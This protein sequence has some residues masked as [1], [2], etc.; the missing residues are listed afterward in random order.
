MKTTLLIASLCWLLLMPLAYGA[1]NQH[2]E[3]EKA[4]RQ[5]CSS[6]TRMWMTNIDRGL[7]KEASRDILDE[8]EES[9]LDGLRQLIAVAEHYASRPQGYSSKRFY[10]VTAESVI[11]AAL[12]YETTRFDSAKAYIT[13]PGDTHRLIKEAAQEYIGKSLELAKQIGLAEGIENEEESV[14]NL[15]MRYT[16]YTTSLVLRMKLANEMFVKYKMTAIAESVLEAFRNELH[17]YSDEQQQAIVSQPFTRKL[18]EVLR[19]LKKHDEWPDAV[20]P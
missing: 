8:R 5:K 6:F 7:Q 20:K 15:V 1:D 10:H 12:S 14:V 13:N 17:E 16:A 18:I 19:Y 3:Y 11:Q 9:N 2:A 4:L